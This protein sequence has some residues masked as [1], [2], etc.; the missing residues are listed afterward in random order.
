MLL[1]QAFVEIISPTY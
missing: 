1:I